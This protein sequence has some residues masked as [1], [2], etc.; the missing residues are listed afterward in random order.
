MLCLNFH[1]ITTMATFWA[2]TTYLHR[3][4]IV[5]SCTLNTPQGLVLN[6]KNQPFSPH[7]Q[8]LSVICTYPGSALTQKS[9]RNC[10]KKVLTGILRHFF[11]DL[12]C[13][14]RLD[15]RALPKWSTGILPDDTQILLLN[16]IFG[17]LQLTV[18]KDIFSHHSRSKQLALI[19]SIYISMLW[20]QGQFF[21][22]ALSTNAPIGTFV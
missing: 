20:I 12:I 17:K 6:W 13:E 8:V 19:K 2:T 7:D 1:T 10:L 16:Y 4:L 3:A 22:F 14:M 9:K 15:S 11:A 18:F 5:F 21:Q